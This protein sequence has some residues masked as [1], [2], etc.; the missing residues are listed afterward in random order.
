V[1]KHSFVFGSLHRSSEESEL[2]WQSECN[3]W[4]QKHQQLIK[5]H[6]AQCDKLVV[7]RDELIRDSEEK[8][9]QQQLSL[10]ACHLTLCFE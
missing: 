5:Q 6:K 10:K 2:N 3:T 1:L 8:Q 4:Q 9:Q 7:E